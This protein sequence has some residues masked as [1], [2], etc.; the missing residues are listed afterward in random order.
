MK[1]YVTSRRKAILWIVFI[2]VICYIVNLFI[3]KPMQ[4]ARLK[5][6]LHQYMLVKANRLEVFN[7]AVA[8]NDGK[9]LNTCVLFASEAMRRNG[10]PIPEGT[11]N[12]TQLISALEDRKWQKDESYQDLQPGDIVFTTDASD[13]KYGKP[14]HC[15]IFMEWA[16]K[17]SYDY[18]YICDNQAGDYK[19]KLYHIRNIKNIERVNGMTKEAFA[20]F[21][22]PWI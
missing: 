13:D 16:E 4:D 5:E 18:A 2:I 6:Q 22:K 7:S 9:T 14:T 19:G 20:F 1:V 8:L 10:I 21:M 15:Y 3:I 12:T 17:G 11:C